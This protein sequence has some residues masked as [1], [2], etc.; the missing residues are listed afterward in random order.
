MLR[1]TIINLDEPRLDVVKKDAIMCTSIHITSHAAVI[2]LA[3]LIESHCVQQAP[4][5][6]YSVCWTTLV[7]A[8]PPIIPMF[9]YI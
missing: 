6:R 1:V 7:I 8:S 5:I 2:T 4:S 9:C 3:H